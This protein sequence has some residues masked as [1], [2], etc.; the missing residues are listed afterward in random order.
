M[1]QHNTQGRY[2]AA[3]AKFIEMA[4][5]MDEAASV[6]LA[7]EL[8]YVRRKVLEVPKA[9]LEAFTVFP[10]QTEVPAGAESAFQRMYDSVGVAKIISNY[11]DDLPRADVVAKEVPVKL[12][13][14]GAAYGYNVSEIRSAQFAGVNLSAMKAKAA[15][16][17]ID[18]KLNSI[19]WKGDAEYGI[20]GFLN[21]PNITEVTIAA[22]GTGS[23][24][25]FNTKTVDKILRDVNKVIQKI[26]DVTNQVEQADTVLIAP[27]AYNYLATTPRADH[28]DLT[29]IE[30]LRR[31]HPEIRRWMKV[32]ALKGVGTNNTDLMIAGKFDPDYIKFEIPMRYNQLPVEY[33]N[34]EYVVN[35]MARGIGVTVTIPL[36]FAKAEGV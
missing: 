13:D 23:K 25:Q 20:T 16:R 21:N 2:D 15:R 36:A 19:A 24:T 28:S 6:F 5:H 14:V 11:A 10:V 30:F 17:S 33:R 1:G 22:D 7:R 35:C 4:G 29:I 26:P 32:S 8:Q 9:P 18:E 27:D 31:T 34:L 12:R 3:E